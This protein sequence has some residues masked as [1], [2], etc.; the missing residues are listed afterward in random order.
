MTDT[1]SGKRSRRETEA[2][3]AAAS[4]VAGGSA[5]RGAIII[6]AA[7]L[8]GVVLLGKGLD[9]GFA[10]TGSNGDNGSSGSENGDGGTTPTGETT[11]DGTAV[12]RPPGEVTV[13]V[14]NGGG[15][16]G[17]ATN[18]STIVANAGYATVPAENAPQDVPQ[19]IIYYVEG[20]Q[21]DAAA[22]AGLLGFPVERVVALPNPPPVP[23]GD[24]Q[25]AAIV[26]VLGPDFQPTG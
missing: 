4:T 26:A 5:V 17:T 6:G 16:T 12:T 19:S 9:T 22:V 25:G 1:G 24:L 14:L 18:G 20:Y 2:Q 11:P 13:W 3:P 15:P 23:N 21:A 8:L 10:S 7:V